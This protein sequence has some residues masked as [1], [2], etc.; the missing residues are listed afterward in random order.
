MQMASHPSPPV[1]TKTAPAKAAAPKKRKSDVVEEKKDLFPE[2]AP[3]ID[4]DDPRIQN[5]KPET[6]NAIRRKIRNWT[7]PGAMKVGE[8]QK[9]IGVSSKAYGSFMNRTGTWDG[10]GCDTYIKAAFFFKKREL[11]GLPLKVSQPKKAKTTSAGAEK[12]ADLPDVS[13]VELP[14]EA[15]GSVPIYDTCDEVRKKIRAMLSRDGMTQAAFIREISKT[16]PDDRRVSAANLRYFMGQKGTTGGNTNATFYAGYVFF[17]KQRIKSGK[18]K[19]KFREEMEKA[20]GTM[21]MDTEHGANTGLF[22]FGNERPYVD[23]YG[24]VQ[25]TPA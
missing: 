24:R 25:V 19:T 9:A 18:P 17:E 8:F 10:E 12:M 21:G 13:G 15:N 20:H 4:D 5:S 1:A 6:C 11:Q 23:K 16:F 14:G 7:E 2:D 3:E 22:C